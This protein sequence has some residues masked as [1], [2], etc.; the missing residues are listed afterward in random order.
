VRFSNLSVTKYAEKCP[1]FAEA[2]KRTEYIKQIIENA[3]VGPVVT[4]FSGCKGFRVLWYDPKLWVGIPNNT[5]YGN[6]IVDFLCS[7]FT[8]LESKVDRSC[9]PEHL[10]GVSFN[11]AWIDPSIYDHQKSIKTDLEPHIDSGFFPQF[12]SD[13]PIRKPDQESL[14]QLHDT[15]M[16]F[17]N[18]LFQEQE[19]MLSTIGPT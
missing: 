11:R 2:L 12:Q 3:N 10:Q 15:I 17:W 1:P 6:A 5:G 9:L 14:K 18:K 4:Y 19:W 7:Y 8:D 16:D 13:T